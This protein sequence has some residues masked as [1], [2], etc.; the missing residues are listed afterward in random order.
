MSDN[1]ARQI[2]FLRDTITKLHQQLAE[3]QADLARAFQIIHDA[4][5]L[6]TVTEADVKWAREALRLE[7]QELIR[8]LTKD[9][10]GKLVRPFTD[11][12][13]QALFGDPP[14]A[15]S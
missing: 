4:Y 8:P 5:P 1:E 13:R 7:H 11:A 15:P 9:D 6:G 10:M 12:E 14:T 3:S 2:E